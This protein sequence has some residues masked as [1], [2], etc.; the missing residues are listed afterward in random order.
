MPHTTQMIGTGKTGDTAADYC[1]CF[2]GVGTRLMKF[3]PVL[4]PVVADKLFYRVNTNMILNLVAVTTVFTW[5]GA[6]PA[7]DG[8]EGIGIGNTVESVLLP[9]CSLRWFFNAT[10]DIQPATDILA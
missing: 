1:D 6:D 9:G 5:C 8:R 7:H 2:A 10:Y 4:Q 3:Q